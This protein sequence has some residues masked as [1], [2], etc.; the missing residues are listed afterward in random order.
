MASSFRLRWYP[1]VVV[2]ALLVVVVVSTVAA[3]GSRALVGTLGGDFPSFYAAGTIVLDG[4]A[5]D[6]YDPQVQE[7]AQQGLTDSEEGVLYFAYPPHTALA[8]APLAA[9][10]YRLA[11][12]LHTVAMGL[13]LWGAVLAGR[14]LLPGMLS[15]GDRVLAATAV[16]LLTYPVLR[17]VLGGQN[18]TLTLALAALAWGLAADDRDVAA[19]VAAGAM[20]FKPQYA[21]V[22]ILLFALARRWRVV[23]ASAATGAVLWAASAVVAGPGWVGEWVDRARAFDAVNVDSNGALMVSIVGFARNVFAGPI[24]VVVI[25]A[26]A[27]VVGLVTAW[28]W[29]TSGGQGARAVAMA[30]PAVPLLAASALYYDTAMM[31][32]PVALAVEHRS[33]GP[34][35]RAG[36][37]LL[38]ATWLQPVAD[39]VGWSPLFVVLLGAWAFAAAAP[40]TRV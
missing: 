39:F 19:G 38:A 34:W 2:L 6:L 31:L 35:A 15:T 40:M 16:A 23:A 13:A 12:L 17:S 8:Y 7:A 14:R 10:P 37:V 4:D 27:G 32:V 3:S 21:V 28:R 29:L 20:L 24:A 11:Y 1:R 25:V 9:L 33:Q 30:A 26:V 18:A 22:V 5:A 36:M